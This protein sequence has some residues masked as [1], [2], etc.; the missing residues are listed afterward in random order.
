MNTQS[1]L[2]P[3][4]LLALAA[5]LI[6][7]LIAFATINNGTLTIGRQTI[8]VMP[9]LTLDFSGYSSGAYGSY[10]PTSLGGGISVVTLYELAVNGTPNSTTFRITGFTSNPGVSYLL[11]L[12]CN[13]VTV[14][15]G[16]ATRTYDSSTGTVTYTW[17]A[18]D[19]LFGL[20]SLSVGTNKSCSVEH[21]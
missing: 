14:A 18:P 10:S 9:G 19:P 21:N 16:H 5:L 7:P 17:S 3:R 2:K 13:G 4:S 15:G 8:P 6:V 20:S 1:L 12:T 11:H